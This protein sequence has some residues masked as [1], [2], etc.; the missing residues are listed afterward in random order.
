MTQLESSL[1]VWTM[2][3]V[4]GTKNQGGKNATATTI[5]VVS[6]SCFIHLQFWFCYNFVTATMKMFFFT[7]TVLTF[8]KL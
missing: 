2:S 6:D 7:Q 5:V 1:D 4:M 3:F 8:C